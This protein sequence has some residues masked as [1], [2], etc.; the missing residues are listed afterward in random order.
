MIILSKANV[1]M[2]VFCHTSNLVEPEKKEE[3]KK[4]EKKEEKIVTY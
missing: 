4:E 3:E 1:Q 2:S